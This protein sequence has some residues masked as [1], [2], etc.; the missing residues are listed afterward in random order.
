MTQTATSQSLVLFPRLRLV[1]MVTMAGLEGLEERFKNLFDAARKR[2]LTCPFD[3]ADALGDLLPPDF[4]E[5]ARDRATAMAAMQRRRNIFPA[6][7][8]P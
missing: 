2:F 3:Y 6:F 1:L 4:M 7:C 8:E 5:I